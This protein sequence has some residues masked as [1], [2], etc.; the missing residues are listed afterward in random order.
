MNAQGYFREGDLP[1]AIAAAQEEVERHPVDPDRRGFLSELLCF[2]GDLE[3]AGRQLD[4]LEQQS[5]ET[6]LGIGLFRHLVRAERA[7]QQFYSEGRPPEFLG[8]PPPWLRLHLEASVCVREGRQDEAVGLLAG[9]EAERPRVSGTCN[10]RAFK[11]L[12]DLDD[13]T[14][15]VFEV[16]TGNGKYY[17]IPIDRVE[18]VEFRTPKRTRELL[19]RPARMIVRDGPDGEVFLPT[20]Y[21]GS[22]TEAGDRFRLGRATEWRGGD[23]APV[24]GIGQRTFLVGDEACPILELATLTIDEGGPN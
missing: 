11:D 18:Q 6:M 20:L 7:R 3:R 14:A 24:R 5:P 23:G 4:P 8:P 12:R 17:W 13:L 1:Q 19:W 9:A 15:G 10:G 22:H 2:A 21:A 16:L